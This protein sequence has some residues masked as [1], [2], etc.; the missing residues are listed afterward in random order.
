MRVGGDFL[1]RRRKE[2]G[3]SRTELAGSIGVSE[4]TIAWLEQGRS[5][6]LSRPLFLTVCRGL[7][8]NHMETDYAERLRFWHYGRE[9]VF[10]PSEWAHV[11]TSMQGVLAYL[12]NCCWDVLAQSDTCAK[13]GLA[14]T[15][16]VDR[17]NLLETALSIWPT[18]DESAV[19]L[20]RLIDQFRVDCAPL[21]GD[22]HV[23]QLVDRL[24][25]NFPVFRQRWEGA[26]FS[27]DLLPQHVAE[28]GAAQFRT[29]RFE[30]RSRGLIL[31][32][33]SFSRPD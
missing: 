32:L 6:S 10:D 25:A 27:P 33:C 16:P 7:Q 26:V 5:F 24:Y 12:T 30:E 17:P 31:Q 21:L 15:V 9:P 18:D 1:R 2:L 23:L 3:L 8:M 20:V 11:V 13:V 4:T 22:P 14:A 19:W 28:I 29:Q